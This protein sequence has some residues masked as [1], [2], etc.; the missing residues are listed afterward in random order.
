MSIATEIL[1]QLQ[2]SDKPHT[3][4]ANLLNAHN[5]SVRKLNMHTNDKT[6]QS[7]LGIRPWPGTNLT[8]GILILFKDGSCLTE[9][10][11]IEINDVNRWKAFDHHTSVIPSGVPE[12]L[13]CWTIGKPKQ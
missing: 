1:S 6:G 12:P 11:A 3:L 2:Q 10:S 4:L 7:W 5:Y 8:N 9:S 13:S